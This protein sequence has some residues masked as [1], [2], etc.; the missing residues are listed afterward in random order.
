MSKDREMNADDLK[1][2]PIKAEASAK[3]KNQR[4]LH[5][6]LPDVYKG[7]LLALVAPIRSSKST[8]WNNLIH[9]ENMFKDLFSDTFIISNTIATDATS[10][11]S[12][13]QFKHTCYEM[14]SDN[15]IKN[16]IKAQRAKIDNDEPDTSFAIIM[17]DL[18]GQFP[19]NGR[20]GMEAIAFSS[21]FRHYVKPNSGDPCLVLYSTQRYY[22]L[23]RVVRN[24]ATGILFSG[25][26]KSKR[27]WDNIIDDY[28]DTFGG[29]DNFR[30]MIA[31]V[32]KEPYTWLYLKL[33]VNPVQA[34]KNFTTQL[35]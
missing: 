6:N 31:E 25:N 23:N 27:E 14:Y 17:D 5:P 20:K 16:I 1:I 11:F 4:Y 35:F 18:L 34:F 8:T 24:N 7:Q 32:Q 22:D 19:K 12:Y 28:G 29:H 30:K 2:I 3:R 10:R 15:I 9:N 21:R 13:E 26:I 33:D